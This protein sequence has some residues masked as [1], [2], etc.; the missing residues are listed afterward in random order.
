[1][2]SARFN[3]TAA[4]AVLLAVAASPAVGQQYQAPQYQGIP[5][6]PPVTQASVANLD[7]RI[8]ALEKQL[9]D[10][11]R[12]EEENAHR[13][14]QLEAQLKQQQ[15]ESSARIASLEARLA[16]GAQAPTEAAVAEPEPE[17]PAKPKATLASITTKSKPSVS[18]DESEDPAEE[19]YDVG[20][21][22]WRAG[23]YDE[24]IGAL[25]AFS[26]AYPKHRRT[27]W[28]NNLAGRA[29]LDKGEPRAAA[30]ALLANYRSNPKGERAADS[31]YYLGQAL[32]KL[33]QASQAC[34]AYAELEA[35]YGSSM[36]GE[37]QTLLPKAKTQAKCS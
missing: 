35:V 22:L 5:V 31:L 6:Q 17:M 25:R 29:M 19:A 14:A 13:I 28:A 4:A 1:M 30:E 27:S 12:A 26:S 3:S 10:L 11:L 15:E 8:V 33:D 37:L 24:A 2:K 32:M 36:R 21:E 16:S 18:A 34:K 23:K 7:G 20:Y 9:A